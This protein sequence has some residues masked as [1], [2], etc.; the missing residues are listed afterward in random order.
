[1]V[2][3]DL[4]IKQ[5]VIQ[6]LILL[7][8]S[9]GYPF[10]DSLRFYLWT[11][12]LCNSLLHIYCMHAGSVANLDRRSFDFFIY[13]RFILVIYLIDLNIPHRKCVMENWIFIQI[14]KKQSGSFLLPIYRKY[15]I[16]WTLYFGYYCLQIQMKKDCTSFIHFSFSIF[17]PST[18]QQKKNKRRLLLSQYIPGSISVILKIRA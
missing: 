5:K 16:S 1:M 12:E 9:V 7:N 10:P 3:A 14:F 6:L 4:Y 15:I 2:I 18:Q 13:F 11:R 17:H 8:K